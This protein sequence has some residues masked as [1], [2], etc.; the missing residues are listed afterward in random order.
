MKNMKN[1]LLYVTMSVMI[2]A[3]ACQNDPK[4]A[5]E[6]STTPKPTLANTPEGVVRQWQNWVDKS[7]YDNASYL[8]TPRMQR[9]VA[10]M[11][12]IFGSDTTA[13]TQYK[14]IKCVTKDTT[15]L[16]RCIITEG[17]E[18]FEDS[19][20]LVKR[21]DQWLI[22]ISEE[23]SNPQDNEVLQNLLNSSPVEEVRKK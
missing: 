8:S 5:A 4:P 11:K 6:Q 3:T 18:I 10:Q 1:T 20:L 21:N 2:L 17:K 22:D 14:S 13:T 9:W 19:A 15:A 7:E 12:N 23:E 16:C